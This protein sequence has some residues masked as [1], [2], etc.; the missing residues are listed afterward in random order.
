MIQILK[1]NLSADNLKYSLKG[2][3]EIVDVFG[4]R[5]GGGNL[6]TLDSE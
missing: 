1:K 2:R 3:D 6:L 4:L 5:G